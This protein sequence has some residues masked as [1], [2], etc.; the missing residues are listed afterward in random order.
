MTLGHDSGYNIRMS[1]RTHNAQQSD[2]DIML[3]AGLLVGALAGAVLMLR[4]SERRPPADVPTDAG[5]ILV[6]G[7]LSD[8]TVQ[9]ARHSADAALRAVTDSR[10]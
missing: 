9:A 2:D 8:D 10:V 7:T 6:P 1:K 4:L 5:R 3:I